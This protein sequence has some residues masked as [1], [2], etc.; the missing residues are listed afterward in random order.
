MHIGLR[1]RRSVWALAFSVLGSLL[2]MSSQAADNP[3]VGTWK[4]DNDKTLREF[5]LPT[6]GSEQLKTDAA[7]AKRFVEGQISNAHSN[8]TLKYT[9]EDCTQVVV[10]GNGLVLSKTSSPSRIVEIGK[11]YVIVDQLKNDGIGK[12]FLN[13]NGFYVEV[14]VGEFTYRDY[15]TRM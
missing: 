13:G 7:R 2:A 4:W 6:E 1:L 8:M 9:D 14:K 11:G 3:L 5:R 10:G 15:F 12:L